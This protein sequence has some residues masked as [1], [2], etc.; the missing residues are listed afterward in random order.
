R[1]RR[2]DGPALT[3]AFVVSVGPSGRRWRRPAGF[4]PG[5][6]SLPAGP[7]GS[8]EGRSPAPTFPGLPMANALKCPNPSCPY[9]FDPTGVPAG[10]V[11]A[12]PRCGMRFTVGPAVTAPTPS[13]V[14]P[15]PAAPAAPQTR[16]P[17]PAA[18]PAKRGGLGALLLPIV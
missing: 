18:P 7:A 12:C 5:L 6:L 11:L 1:N 16:E 9:L 13:P 15:P 14:A 8:A 3:R 2:P 4:L 17:H 10:V